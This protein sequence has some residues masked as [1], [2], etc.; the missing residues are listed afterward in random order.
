MATL[1][2]DT[3]PVTVPALTQGDSM[4]DIVPLIELPAWVRLTLT[5]P[6]TIPPKV[7]LPLHVPVMAAAVCVGIGEG[8]GVGPSV[9]EG[10]QYVDGLN[11]RTR[12]LIVS[13]A[14]TKL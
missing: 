11:P 8:L 12:V 1:E 2:P 13:P 3:E 9:G 14:A 7:Q 4:T 5:V 6:T 10:P